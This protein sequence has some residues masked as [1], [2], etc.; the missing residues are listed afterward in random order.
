VVCYAS[1]WKKQVVLDKGHEALI[2][3]FMTLIRF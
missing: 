1:V 2:E 3:I